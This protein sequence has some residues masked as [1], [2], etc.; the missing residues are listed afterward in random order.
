[1]NVVV[2][3]SD[4][5]TGTLNNG[6][7]YGAANPAPTVSAISPATG[8][9]AGGTA[10]T[11]TGTGFLTGATV[12][13]GG[14]TAT[15]VNV[16]SSTSITATA[17]AHSAGS[18]SVVVINTDSQSGTLTNGY[19]YT[20]P[21]PKVTSIAPTSG[22]AAGGTNVT[23]TGTGFLSG[24]TLSL[25]GAVATG[26]NVVNSTSITA[27]TAAHA[28]GVVNVVV[29]NSDSQSSTLA[30]AYTYVAA[31]TVTAINPATGPIAGGNGA[32]IT[33]ANFVSGATVS[34][35]G[36]AATGV[37]VAGSAVIT[38]TPPAH[39]AGTVEVV[40]ANPDGQSSKLTNGYTYSAEPSLGLGIPYGD[41]NSATV[42][43]GQTATY[44]LSIG[45]EGMS[46]TASLSC[47]SAP[48]GSTCSLPST[49]A[50]NATTPTTFTVKV[51][52]TA[53]ISAALSRPSLMTPASSTRGSFTPASWLWTLSLGMLFVPRTGASK[54]SARPGR[55]YLWLSPIL[56]L[57]LFAVSCGGGG[58]M[59]N[60]Q[61]QQIG[62]PAGT[63]T[64]IVNATSNSKSG[65][66]SLTLNVQ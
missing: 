39:S 29:T 24:A 26:V 28:A 23:I 34:F 36:T 62:T 49:L 60:A 4:N 46:G 65:S 7:S 41:P 63:Y 8:T 1:V 32:T 51:V 6:Y 57:L 30:N 37:T 9:T 5:Q 61:P 35:G 59:S 47:T 56:L 58:G 43:A 52:T 54:R 2:T 45:G 3:N 10:V 14:T 48:T 55:R 22:P 15:G 31:P 18:V 17:P 42:A 20:N 33:G 44:T 27:T 66:T 12:K 13:L 50:F 11:I 64:V 19:S 21:A 38:A 40:V 25:G 16:V 53:R